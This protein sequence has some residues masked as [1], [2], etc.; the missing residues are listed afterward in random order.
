MEKKANNRFLLIFICIFLAVVIIFGATVGIIIG[1]KNARAAAKYDGVTVD[2]GVVRCLASRYKAMYLKTLN[3]MGIPA[4]DFAAFWKLDGGDGKSYGELLEENFEAYLSSILVANSLYKMNASFGSDERKIVSAAAKKILDETAEGSVSKFNEQVAKYGFDYK[5]FK[6]ACELLYKAQMSQAL[7]YGSDGKNLAA[8]PDE[9]MKYLEKYS[10]V[11]LLFIRT[12]DKIYTDEEGKSEII[13]LTPEEK[14]QKQ[15]TLSEIR[16]AISNLESG[17]DGKMNPQMFKGYL[18]KSDGDPSYHTVGYYF[19]E[20]AAAT[21]EFAEEY[22]DVVAMAYEMSVGDYRE[23]KIDTDTFKGYCFLYKSEVEGG[24]YLSTTNVFLSDFYS[25][26]ALY[27]YN[28][29][30]NTLIPDVE[31][32]A[33]YDDI[34]LVSIPKNVVYYVK[35]W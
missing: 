22:G 29:V 28:E 8:Y 19:Y 20:N 6:A 3:S 2:E 12:D 17:E 16:L 13:E 10:H 27:L 35:V 31:Y 4:D 24:A 33:K 1:T 30:L 25:D 32:T 15:A 11:H 5:D 21:R 7:Y 14:A 9:C 18:E 34:D 23:V 26:A